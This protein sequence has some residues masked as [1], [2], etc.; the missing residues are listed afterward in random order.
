MDA[1]TEKAETPADV[2][3]AKRAAYQRGAEALRQA[4]MNTA[5]ERYAWASNDL[6]SDSMLDRLEAKGRMDM[7]TEIRLAIAE[8]P[9]P[10]DGD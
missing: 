8:M 3:Q 4:A 5:A 6:D 7:A 1:L 2:A 10:E 9:I